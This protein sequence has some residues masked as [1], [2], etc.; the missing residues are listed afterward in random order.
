M[1]PGAC[2]RRGVVI[3]AR[4]RGLAWAGSIVL[5]GCVAPTPSELGALGVE[6][7]TGDGSGAPIDGDTSG[8]S[9]ASDTEGA[10]PGLAW[11]DSSMCR[12]VS[13]E[14]LCTEGVAARS[15]AEDAEYLWLGD[16]AS[17][18][19][20][21]VSRGG[22]VLFS[23]GVAQ[24]GGLLAS[25]LAEATDG[26]LFIAG[27]GA[28]IIAGTPLPSDNLAARFVARVTAAGEVR[29][30]K[31][32]ADVYGDRVLVAPQV[33]GGVV[34][35]ADLSEDLTLD[36]VLVPGGSI[37]FPI[38]LAARFTADGELAWITSLPADGAVDFPVASIESGPAGE[39]EMVGP[40]RGT[41]AL[42][43]T[44]VSFPFPEADPAY[45]RVVLGSD[46]H[47]LSVAAEP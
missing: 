24:G 40:L 15:W 16:D 34:I 20:S 2:Y 26:D 22:A 28:A 42:G 29:W 3:V 19:A 9:G 35:I 27:S 31:H 14:L 18:S 39:I 10:P 43:D 32:F 17:W 44:E 41:I 46:G 1:T 37:S 8:S 7:G 11:P 45:A 33:D 36:G 13:A 6:R 30:S 47:W 12:G 5:A 38:P 4:S 21:G 25:G 23:L